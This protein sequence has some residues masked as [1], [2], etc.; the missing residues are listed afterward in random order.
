MPMEAGVERLWT[1][2][3]MSYVS[4]SSEPPSD[5]LFCE[6]SEQRRDAENLLLQRGRHAFSLVNLYPYNTGHLMVAP[7]EHSAD[8]ANLSA[9][10]G[11]EM[12]AL[13]AKHCTMCHARKPTH[14]SFQEAPKNVTLESIGEIR[15][16]APLILTQTVQNKAMP[17]GNQTAMTED[18]RRKIGRWIAAQR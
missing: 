13:T 16:Y 1:P 18:E 7:Y 5:C 8:L 14:E 17:L 10:V 2:W 6:L 12:L 15:K 3:R 9:E 11:A 4:G